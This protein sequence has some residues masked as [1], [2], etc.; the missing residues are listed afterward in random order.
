[1]DSKYDRQEVNSDCY[2]LRTSI[3]LYT[4]EYGGWGGVKLVISIHQGL[5][6]ALLSLHKWQPPPPQGQIGNSISS[7]SQVSNTKATQLRR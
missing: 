2:L 7:T 4:L 3:I 6:L 5:L 1:V